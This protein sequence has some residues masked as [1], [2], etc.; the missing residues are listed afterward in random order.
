M[1]DVS[2]YVCSS[3][4]G[5]QAVVRGGTASVHALP[6]PE[7]DREISGRS[8][9]IYFENRPLREV[10]DEMGR[11]TPLR[12]EVGRRAE[13][14]TVGGTFQTNPQGAE[15]LLAMLEDGLGLQVR[16]EDG[17]R[18][19]EHTSELPSIMRI[20][21]DVFSLETKTPYHTLTT[22]VSLHTHA[23]P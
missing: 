14:I 2:S 11:Y 19:E 10:I 3:D 13:A 7:V 23:L 9:T 22:R 5:Q 18:S 15:A 6:M 21:Y 1:S 8:G 4:P 16:S 12:I 17:K 20:S